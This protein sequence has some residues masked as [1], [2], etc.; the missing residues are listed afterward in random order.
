MSATHFK[1]SRIESWKERKTRGGRAP[2]DDLARCDCMGSNCRQ[3]GCKGCGGKIA[4]QTI[5]GGDCSEGKH[6]AKKDQF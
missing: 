6:Q 2:A 4:S 1:D 5:E 3:Q